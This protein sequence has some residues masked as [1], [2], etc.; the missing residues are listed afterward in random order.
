VPPPVVIYG[1]PTA[2][3]LEQFRKE[4][5]QMQVPDPKIEVERRLVEGNPATEI[6]RTSEET[7]CD[8]IV[9]GSHGR[10]GLGRLVLGSVAEQVM[11]QAACPVLIVK[12]PLTRSPFPDDDAVN[13]AGTFAVHSFNPSCP[14]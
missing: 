1:P 8:A 12:T 7:H 2:S 10:T 4:L 3:Y 11:R 9:M 6:L 14:R 13:Q 5:D